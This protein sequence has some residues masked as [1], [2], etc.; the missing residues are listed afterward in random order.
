M[1]H[2]SPATLKQTKLNLK[3]DLSP[4]RLQP[5]LSTTKEGAAKVRS[6]AANLDRLVADLNS[7]GDRHESQVRPQSLAK[8]F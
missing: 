2:Q 8:Q 6:A 3:P 4:A 1:T 5:V 7:V